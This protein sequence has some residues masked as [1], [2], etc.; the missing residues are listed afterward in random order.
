[1]NRVEWIQSSGTQYIDLGRA[2]SNNTRI[3]CTVSG[4]DIETNGTNFLYGARRTTSSADQFG[5]RLINNA[6]YRCFFYNSNFNFEKD[7][8][9]SGKILIDHNKNACTIYPDA[10]EPV[11]ASGISGTFTCNYNMYLFAEN[12]NGVAQ[13]PAS[14]YFYGL[15]WYESD[16]LVADYVPAIDDNG[17]AGVYERVSKTFLYN[18]GTGDFSHGD[19]L[20]VFEYKHFPFGSLVGTGRIKFRHYGDE[21]VWEIGKKQAFLNAGAFVFVVPESGVYKAYVMNGGGGGGRELKT[22]VYVIGGG[23]GGSSGEVISATYQKGQAVSLD[24]G[25]GGSVG[26]NGGFTTIDGD[27]V[28]ETVATCGSGASYTKPGS[29]GTGGGSLGGDGLGGKA[30]STSTAANGEGALGYVYEGEEY[31]YGGRGNQSGG[32]GCV[33][34]ELVSY[35]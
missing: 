5:M 30:E 32:D 2:P 4:Y 15:Q 9:F 19:V 35:T 28:C 8:S 31:G 34:F 11:T 1:M 23:G 33:I 22:G 27:I 26:E 21:H 12:R 3:K 16:V 29:A 6:N 7:V 13:I 24:I 17:V 10:G 25:K 18:S 14:V 20:D